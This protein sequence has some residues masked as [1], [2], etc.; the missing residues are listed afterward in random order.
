MFF[1]IFR[2]MESWMSDEDNK[3]KY[4]Q[5]NI[6]NIQYSFGPDGKRKVW[7]NEDNK[8]S[9]VDELESRIA[10]PSRLDPR[11]SK[12][13][14][15]D[16][17]DIRKDPRL[18]PFT[19]KDEKERNSSFEEIK[20]DPRINSYLEKIRTDSPNSNKNFDNENKRY[21]MTRKDPRLAKDEEEDF[22]VKE[23]RGPRSPP[24]PP[25]ISNSS[26]KWRRDSSDSS[27]PESRREKRETTRRDRYFCKLILLSYLTLPY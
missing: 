2:I 1:F 19:K 4:R 27:S 3:P 26:R 12:T 23:K 10:A 24:S 22:Y 13:S 5:Q 9:C 8:S 14:D 18:N 6:R 11:L 16:Q 17:A 20:K 25:D 15:I 21:P 7:R